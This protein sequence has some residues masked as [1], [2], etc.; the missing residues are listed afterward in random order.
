MLEA[1]VSFLE[2]Q[3]K[4]EE[5]CFSPFLKIAKGS[6]W[7]GQVI[8][9]VAKRAQCAATSENTCKYKKHQQI[10]KASSS[11]WQQVLQMLTTQ[12]NKEL[13]L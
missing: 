13:Y 1:L 3:I 10:K 4:I 6:D 9:T 11:I 7:V 5:M 2:G 12:P 8:S